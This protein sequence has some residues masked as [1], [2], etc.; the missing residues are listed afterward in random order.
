M[1][2]LFNSLSESL[3]TLSSNVELILCLSLVEVASCS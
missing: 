1:L 2:Y 3:T